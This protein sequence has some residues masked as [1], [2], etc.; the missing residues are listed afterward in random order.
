MSGTFISI[1]GKDGIVKIGAEI[2]MYPLSALCK[3]AKEDELP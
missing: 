1:D 2:H 3:M